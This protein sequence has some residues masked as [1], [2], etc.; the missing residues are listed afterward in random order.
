MQMENK[1]Q[2]W[3]ALILRLSLVAI[4]L[5]AGLSKTFGIAVWW[6][7]FG[8][9]ATSVQGMIAMG[10]SVAPVW[11]A[12]AMAY[13]LPIVHLYNGVALLLGYAKKLTSWT[14]LFDTFSLVAFAFLSKGANFEWFFNPHTWFFVSAIV[15]LLLPNYGKWSLGKKM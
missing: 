11:L 9:Y 2:D 5:P 6:A 14:V 8:G 7:D 4:L 12:M 15:L 10:S 3:A 13:A 1:G